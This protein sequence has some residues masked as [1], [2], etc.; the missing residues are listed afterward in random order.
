MGN[1]LKEAYFRRFSWILLSLIGSVEFVRGAMFLALVPIFV[2]HL[3]APVYTHHH[4]QITVFL[5]GAIISAM[6]GADTI[7]KPFAGWLVDYFGPRLTLL[8]SLPWA[9]LGLSTFLWSRSGVVLLLGAIFFGLGCAPVWPAVV[10]TMVEH[11]P[12]DEQAETLSSVFVAWMVGIGSGYVLINLFFHLGPKLLITVLLGIFCLPILLVFNLRK[13]FARKRAGK[14]AG[15]RRHLIQ[16]IREVWNLRTLLTGSFAQTLATSMLV[17]L[18]IPFFGLVYHLDQTAYGL[19]ILIVGAITVTL[20]VPVGK[21]VDRL[22]YRLFLV[23]GCFLTGALLLAISGYPKPFLI[24]PY[25]ILLGISYAFFLPSW[26]GLLAQLMPSSVRGSL[27]SIFMSIDGLG[28][29]LGPLIGGKLGDTYGFHSAF[30]VSAAI[31]FAMAVFYLLL[32]RHRTSESTSR[33]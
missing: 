14:V 29:A 17:P 21:L 32:L 7:T 3:A 4:I 10:S 18:L 16:M 27:Y 24:Y 26:N 20:M 1:G 6:Y 8:F 30:G 11:S 15:P 12:S 23:T 9:L 25:G 5:S 33:R 31:M 19:L 2:P 28:M 13:R 22:G